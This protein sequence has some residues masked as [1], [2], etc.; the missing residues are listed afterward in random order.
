[1][2][3]LVYK[4]VKIYFKGDYDTYPVPAI[5]NDQGTKNLFNEIGGSSNPSKCHP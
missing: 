2:S 4:Y 1:M 5:S 3:Q